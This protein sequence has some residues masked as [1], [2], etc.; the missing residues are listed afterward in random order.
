MSDQAS[1]TGPNTAEPSERS[2]L[3]AEVRPSLRLSTGPKSRASSESRVTD[4]RIRRNSENFDR[5]VW[6]GSAICAYARGD[7]SR[8]SY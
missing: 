6:R 8:A 4:A 3:T 1:P 7:L 2:G 5:P